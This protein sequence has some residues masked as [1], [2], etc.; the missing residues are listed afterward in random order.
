[1]LVLARKVNQVITIGD[2]IRIEVVHIA[3]HKVRLGITAPKDVAVH[4]LETKLAIDAEGK[5][6]VNCSAIS[7]DSQKCDNS[8]GFSQKK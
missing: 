5:R 2:D 8:Q 7:A 6:D 3:E 4:R 1:M